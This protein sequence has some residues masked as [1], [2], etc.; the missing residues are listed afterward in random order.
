MKLGVYLSI[1]EDG[2]WIA[3]CV[4]LRG[5]V[6]QG[7]TKEEALSNIQDAATECALVRHAQGLPVIIMGVDEFTSLANDEFEHTVEVDY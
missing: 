1:D 3:E 5:C 7:K 2:M 6:S 4:A